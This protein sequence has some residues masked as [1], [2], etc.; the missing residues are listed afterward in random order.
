MNPKIFIGPMSKII[1]DSIIEIANEQKVQIGLIPSRRQVDYNGGYVNNWKTKTFSEY[2]KS[3]T[4][5]VLLIR[6]HAGPLQGDNEDEGYD[7]MSYDSQYMDIIHVDVWKK[8]T[9]IEDGIKKTIDFINFCYS[10]NPKVLFEI[11]TEE[12]IRKFSAE[13]LEYLISELKK[14]LDINVFNQIKYAVIQC[15][16]GLLG[17]T[18]FRTFDES[19][20]TSMIEICKKYNLLSKEHNG[21]YQTIEIIQNK[22][23]LGLNSINIAPEFGKIETEAI[24]DFTKDDKE[25]FDFFYTLCY[26]SKKWVKWVNSNFNPEENKLDLILISGHYVFSNIDF[27]NKINNF[28]GIDSFIKERIR[29]RLIEL[30]SI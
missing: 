10:M 25:F 24:L 18:N 23:K 13:E 26:K 2:V 29:A 3:R 14:R 22:F 6:D 8:Y 7:S 12:S 19:R 5:N 27:Q 11:G 30:L 21:D 17:N 9:N 28:N 16:T 4:N 15:G 20:L 1:V